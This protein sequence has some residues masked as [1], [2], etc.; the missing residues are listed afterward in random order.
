M[1]YAI[2]MVGLFCLCP[3]VAIH[4]RHDLWSVKAAAENWFLHFRSCHANKLSTAHN[5]ST[6]LYCLQVLL[7]YHVSHVFL[8]PP[9]LGH[10]GNGS[11]NPR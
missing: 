1:S 2:E 6:W 7:L 5:G 3:R 8:R 11:D 9:L 10:H 4:C